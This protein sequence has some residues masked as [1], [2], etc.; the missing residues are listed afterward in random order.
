MIII[1]R[2]VKLLGKFLMMVIRLLVLSL[3]IK[4]KPKVNKKEKMIR[5]KVNK[6]DQKNKNLEI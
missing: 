4:N 6:M 2:G 5:K 3:S 1:F